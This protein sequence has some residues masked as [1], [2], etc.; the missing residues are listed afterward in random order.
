MP[1]YT[2]K[3]FRGSV[4]RLEPHLLNVN[5]ARYALDCKLMH[6]SIE[7]WR[8]LRLWKKSPSG[9]AKTA[10]CFNG[11]WGFNDSCIDWAAGDVTCHR[12]FVT[13]SDKGYP[14]SISYDDNCNERIVRLGVPCPS[15]AISTFTSS[16]NAI[17][18][19]NLEGRSYAYA[20]VSQFEEIGA[21]SP[22]STVQ[23]V[24][25]GEQVLL[26]GWQVPDESWEVAKVNIYR[27]VS[28]T[29]IGVQEVGAANN[30]ST[31]WQLVAQIPVTETSYIDTKYNEDLSQAYVEEYCK[32]PP[33]NLQ[34]ICFISGT[35]S[36]AGYVG[37][38]IYFSLNNS[39][40]NWR[41]YHDLD[42]NIKGIIESEGVLYIATD[43]K[44]YTVD[45]ANIGE[46][47]P[48]LAVRIECPWP[49]VSCG[50]RHLGKIN[51][52]VVYPTHDGLVAIR[53]RKDFALVSTPY[54]SPVQWQELL[55]STIIPVLKGSHL[56]CFGKRGS[57]ILSFNNGTEEGWD[58]DTHT[59][60]SDTDVIDAFLTRSGDLFLLK[61]DGNVYE[62]DKGNKFR[63][64]YW[65]SSI[66]VTDQ[67]LA[68]AAWHVKVNNGESIMSLTANENVIY[69]VTINRD[70]IGTLPSWMFGHEW[71]FN[72]TGTGTV[73]YASVS[74]SMMDFNK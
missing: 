6:G 7:P 42:D 74:T 65:E 60:I 31:F 37:N 54:Y 46:N 30:F 45:V 24:K 63:T 49:C 51:E 11:C 50:N 62:W 25:D 22:P 38:R 68:F 55:P 56:F 3:S 5:Q 16:S 9:K 28:G 19:K 12:I 59:E 18:D 44:P 73:L 47:K 20:Y 32:P 29:G 36:L 21:L 66:V 35:N 1:A 27:S 34:G 4:P 23:G 41:E 48:R 10:F 69:S 43:G 53:G 61:E 2:I 67:P 40:H 26:S 52:G 71:S 13:G 58:Y 39:Y 72:F 70:E 14:I 15:T 33:A 57:F 64:Y 17:P 8:E